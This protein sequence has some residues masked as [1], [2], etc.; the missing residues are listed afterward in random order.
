M[1]NKLSKVDCRYGAS[2]GRRNSIPNNY[3]PSHKLHLNK[4][5]WHGDYDEGGAYWGRTHN[6][7][8]YRAFR[9]SQDIEIFVRASSRTE[10][11]DKLIELTKLPLTF[12]R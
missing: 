9:Y 5:K 11:K 8:I 4:L 10:A 3:N 1:K 6:T 2:M 12:L 7:Y